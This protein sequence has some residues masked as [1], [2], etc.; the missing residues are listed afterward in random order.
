M[1]ASRIMPHR[2][3]YLLYLE[4]GSRAPAAAASEQVMAA[5]IITQ[6]S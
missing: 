1:A 4:L 5:D 2:A 3:V 6:I